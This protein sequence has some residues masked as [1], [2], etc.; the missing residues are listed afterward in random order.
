MT[1]PFGRSAHLGRQGVDIGVKKWPIWPLAVALIIFQGPVQKLEAQFQTTYTSYDFSTLAGT[2][3]ITGS[4]D[5]TGAAAQFDTPLGVAVDENGNVYVADRYNYTI[6]KIAPGGVVTTLAGTAGVTGSTDGTG[7]AAQFGGPYGV[8]VDGSGNVYV[9]DVG[10][11]TIR[12]IA[13]GGI[14]TTLAGT[15]GVRGSADGTGPAAQFNGPCGV[16]VDG[17]GNVYVADTSN[18]TIRKITPSGVT[19]TLAGTPGV[20]GAADGTGAAA[21]FDSPYGVAVDTSGNVYVAD[22]Y[23]STIRVI[24][25]SGVTTTLAGTPDVEGVTDATGAAARFSLPFGVAVDGSGN[26]YVTDTSSYIVRKVTPGGIV[27]TIA[28]IASDSGNVDGIG[29]GAQFENPCGIAADASGDVYVTDDYANTVRTGYPLT[30]DQATVTLGDLYQIY[31]GGPKSVLVT[32]TPAGLSTI[33]YYWAQGLTAPIAPGTYPFFAGITDPDYAGCA[34]GTLTIAPGFSTQTPA[35]TRHS[36]SGGSFLWS[37]TAGVAGLVAV[38]TNGTILGSSDGATWTYRD[39][40]TTNWLVGITYGEGQYVAVGDN[41]CVLLSADGVAWLSVA[42]SA[43]TERLNNVIYA[44]GEYVAV[45]EGG[46]IVSSPDGR[47]WTARNSGLTG[48]LRGLT[49]VGQYDFTYGLTPGSEAGTVPARF[50]ASGEGGTIISSTDGITW[51]NEFPTY[52]GGAGN[53]GEDLEA[54]VTTQSVNFAAV[55]ADGDFLSS[56]WETGPGILGPTY[57]PVEGIVGAPILIPVDFRGLV[58]GSNGLFAT[59]DNGTI[60][61]ASITTNG[62]GPWSQISSGTTADLVGAAAI[63]D[64]VYVVGVNETILELTAPYDSRLIN[65]SCRAQVGT[66]TNA[67]ITGFVIGGQGNSGSEPVLIRGSGPALVPFGVSGTLPDPELQLYSTGSGGSLLSTNTSW[68]GAPAISS[69]AAAVGAFA[70]SNPSSHDVALIPNLG[71]GSYTANLFGESGD[72]GVALTEVYDATPAGTAGPSSPRLTNISARSHVG[73]GGS[74]LIAG[75][76]IAGAT[77]KT[78]LIRASGPALVPFGLTGTLPDPELAVFGSAPGSA[79]LAT[80]TG[81]GASPQIEIAAA[82]V[83]AFSWGSSATADSAIL[84]TLPP[85]A[86]TAEV[87]GASGDTGIALVEVYEVQ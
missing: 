56:R 19:T 74:I 7:A 25:P 13:P 15:P 3:G 55:G 9:S 50:V 12:K 62:F 23:N 41:G 70:W 58:L 5:G 32:T 47:K 77:P 44:A 52:G 4:A 38:G 78:V 22:T 27:T 31:D 11:A 67:L 20:V 80:N 21:Q 81:W 37:I 65:L 28:G 29:P 8:A 10:N 75:F 6:R 34:Y 71:P 18:N 85:G 14:V 2:A 57:P 59:G 53:L 82:W 84:I 83:G 64:S 46:A 42:Q 72:T 24:T 30:Q 39:S 79:A 76:V 17:N 49:Y 1:P 60:A 51:G 45:G 36:K 33:V 73:S 86:Y 68:S 66:A 61:T 87:S 43:T 48:W 26:V 16:A 40:G 54:L 63:G 69:E 35:I